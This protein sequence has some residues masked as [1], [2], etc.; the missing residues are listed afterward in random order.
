MYFQAAY[1][2]SKTI[3]NVS[4]SQSTDELNATR[5]GQGGG[6]ILN[7]QSNVQ[8]NKARGDFDRPHRLV[9]SYAYDLPVPKNSFFQNQF[10]RGWAISGI[11]TYQSG[12]PFSITDSTSGGIF[13][14]TGGGTAT[15]SG[16]CT[17]AAF[18]NIGTRQQILDHYLNPIC[19]T[20]A[21]N[22]PNSAGLG[23]AI[24]GDVPRNAF[25]G[26]M[27]QNWDFALTKRFTLKES[28][29]FQ[30]RMDVFNLWNHPVFGFPSSVN[31]GSPATLGQI[32]TT[33]VPARLI[34]FNLSYSH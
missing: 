25:R 1:T 17:P 19:F 22:A 16:N 3:D 28:H 11:V 5:A 7:N 9:V 29:V 2:F 31:I 10:F 13:G 23:R 32:T 30:A 20:T 33:V 18:Y 8:Q 34:Q 26:P 27:Q 6:N 14:Q 12:Q 21:P 24:F 15:L 4:G